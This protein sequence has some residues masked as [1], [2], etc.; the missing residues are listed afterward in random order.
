MEIQTHNSNIDTQLVLCNFGKVHKDKVNGMFKKDARDNKPNYASIEAIYDAIVPELK[1]NGLHTIAYIPE[2]RQDVLVVKVTHA[3]SGTFISTNIKLINMSD[4]QK[5]SASRTYARKALAELVG[6]PIGDDDDDGNTACAQNQVTS[7]FAKT[8]P[9][10][11]TPQ[12]KAITQPKLSEEEE[13]NRKGKIT[14]ELDQL[15][16]KKEGSIRADGSPK[17]LVAIKRFENDLNG[18]SYD[19]LLKLKE[20][21]LENNFVDVIIPQLLPTNEINIIH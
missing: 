12:P 9:I 15:W 8:A 16:K 1:R 17:A 18:L 20:W 10:Y 3:Q 13:L 5:S 11:V 2:D 6:V 4:M 7:A 21:I 14:F 19:S